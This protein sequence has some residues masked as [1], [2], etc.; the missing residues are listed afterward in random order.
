MENPRL[1]FATPTHPRRR[2]LAGRAGRARAGPLLVGQPGD[3]RR[4]GTTSGSTRASPSTSRTGSWR[5]STAPSTPPCCAPCRCRTS[6]PRSSELGADSPDTRLHLDLA[7]R[8]PDDGMTVDRLRQGRRAAA[9]ARGGRRPRALG[10]LPARL[11]RRPTP[12]ARSPPSDF[13]ESLTDRAGETTLPRGLRSRRL[14]LRPRPARRPAAA[15]LGRV[16]RRRG[17]ARRAGAQGTAAARP[18]H[19]RLDHPRVAALP[20]PAA[21][22]PETADSW[23]SSTRPSA[24]PPPAT[25]RSSP[26]GS[27]WRSAPATSPPTRRSRSFLTSVGR[28]KFLQAALHRAGQERSGPGLGARGLHRGPRRL[29]RHRPQHRRRAARLGRRG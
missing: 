13:R 19:R 7:G 22:R 29:P 27:R 10:R 4:P 21:R 2:P 17:R 28:R 25:A 18:R 8:D 12:S 24:S 6:R 5:R 15:R 14:A 16:S 9:A 20:A 23:P 11:L 26:P 3:Q 1:T